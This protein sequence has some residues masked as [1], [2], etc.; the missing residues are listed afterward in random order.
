MTSQGA[1]G[2]R[3][4]VISR[5]NARNLILPA[6]G[7]VIGGKV[8]SLQ[9]TIDNFRI[10]RLRRFVL[11]RSPPFETMNLP[12]CFLR[13]S[14]LLMAVA[15]EA[16]AAS[17]I[18]VS[19]RSPDLAP[20]VTGSGPSS[21]GVFVGPATE[22]G[23]RYVVFLSGAGNLV[24]VPMPMGTV[25]VF[26]RDRVE[27]RTERLSLTSDGAVGGRPV[28][29]FSVTPGGDRMVFAWA[30]HDAPA[31]DTNG[32]EDVYLREVPA[33][34][35]RL[36]S[37]RADGAGPGN[38]P[39]GAPAISADGRF[40]VFESLATD[41]VPGND[42]NHATDVFLRNLETD[43]TLRISATTTGIPG[44]RPSRQPLVSGDGSR[45]VFQSDSLNLAPLTNYGTS[46]LV[47]TRGESALQRV[48]LPG[49]P[50][51]FGPV[52]VADPVLSTNG[53]YL[54]FAFPR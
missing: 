41:L 21:G 9:F 26:R 7:S 3:A 14:V 25:N 50:P 49:D 36:V 48:T 34:V 6:M 45:V 28:L 17:P 53:R 15:F 31:G 39:S 22:A 51:F 12:S 40:V 4:G 46:L 54:A 52:S 20:A 27:H 16:S 43:V 11:R 42:T 33:G 35:T 29:E 8:Y 32:W 1:P 37:A 5:R 18:L 38:G 23:S 24:D 30:S 44:D 13:L 19:A 2:L 10:S 47:W